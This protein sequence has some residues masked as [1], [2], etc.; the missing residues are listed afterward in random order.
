[1]QMMDMEGEEVVVQRCHNYS[2]RVILAPGS[3]MGGAK[4]V[5]LELTGPKAP[6]T[7]APLSN[8]CKV[9]QCLFFF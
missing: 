5:V 8:C 7:V 3:S 6:A 9:I 2:S 4:F 1:M